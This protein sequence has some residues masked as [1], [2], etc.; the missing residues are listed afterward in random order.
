MISEPLYSDEFVGR[1]DELSFLEEAFRAACE[2]RVRFVTVEGEAGIGKSRLVAEFCKGLAS[3]ATVVSGACSEHVRAPY[4]P[5]EEIFERLDPR[6]TETR[7]TAADETRAEQKFAYFTAVSELIRRESARR[8]L[9]LVIEDAQWADSASVEL[10]CFLLTRPYAAR[11]LIVVTMR[12]ESPEVHPQA[13]MLRSAASRGRAATLQ[14]RALRRHEVRRLVQQSLRNASAP[15]GA[16]MLGQIEDLAEGNPLFAEELAQTFAET[17]SLSFDS[18]MP[19]S[20][21][22]LLAERLLSFSDDE[23]EML[24]RAAVAGQ[25][26][27]AAFVA[28]IISEPLDRVL[29][30]LQRAV[31]AGLA[32]EQREIENRFAF[33]HALIRQALSDQLVLALAAPLHVRIAEAIE[34]APDAQNRAAE[35]AYHWSAARNAAKA[36]FW[37]ESAGDAAWNVFAYRDA[38]RC[39]ADALKWNYPG[40]TQRAA[41]Y[42]RI[43]TL[44]YIEGSGDEPASWFARSEAEYTRCGNAVG[45]AHAR[46]LEAD[47]MWV[48]ARTQE[49]LAA[50]NEAA[51]QLKR[52]GH[53]ALEAQA[54]LSVARYAVTLGNTESARANLASAKRLSGH[55]DLGSRASWHEVSGEAHS[56]CGQLVPALADFRA[57][58]R[59]AAQ[60]GVSELIAQIE[61]NFAIAAFDL[62]DLDLANARHQI[63]VDEAQ[64]TG[65]LWRVAYSSLNYARTLM[66]KGRLRRARDLVLGAIE[67]GVTT[68]TFR[69]KAACVGIPLALLLNDRR[70]LDACAGEDVLALARQSGESQRIAGV[71]AA[72]A[73]LRAAQGS[74]AEAR[75][76]VSDALR[77]VAAPHRAWELL[78]AAAVWGDDDDA[79]YAAA[80]FEP[81]RARPRVKRAYRL[82][83]QALRAGAAGQAAAKRLGRAA[84]LQFEGMGDALHA[85]MALDAAGERD[86]ALRAYERMEAVREKPRAVQGLTRRQSEIARLVSDGRTN[87]EIA[88]VLHISEHTVEHHV[89]GIFER[90]GL[91]SRAQLAHVMGLNAAK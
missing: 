77:A 11:A 18:R 39:Y 69:T 71:A 43:G 20:L 44:L 87:R 38:I 10:L 5:F 65:M 26:F 24:Y 42:E 54:L 50:A 61:N 86:D 56:A 30:V 28:G 62:G 89:S 16:E 4:F 21:Q 58:A 73:A 83:F 14:L 17:G 23:R 8:P 51:Q 91:H 45:A 3:R 22:A 33:R 12:T 64:R 81:A 48:D 15:I 1:R 31:R 53:A 59:F 72:F 36:R 52:L 84:H 66:F 75:A 57:A 47:Q 49:S 34:A 46:L 27:D 78:V 29:H 63:A 41:L 79:A 68:A 19:L 82:L 25:T 85:A 35:L 9:V 40:G 76:L 60:S 32:V 2:A 13:A 67:T 70:L 80:L 37:S 88:Q 6:S 74:P 90:L 7:R 55:F